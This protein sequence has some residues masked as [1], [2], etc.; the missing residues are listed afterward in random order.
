MKIAPS[1]LNAD[2]LNL[3]VV[4]KQLSEADY[5]HVDVMDGVF[6]PNISFGPDITTQISK[7]TKIPLDVHLMIDDP[8]LYIDDFARAKPDFITVHV[9]SKRY[10][11]ALEKIKSHGIKKGI[12]IKPKTQVQDIID[13]LNYVDLVL[14][15]SVEP[16]FGGQKFMHESLAK[17]EELVKIRQEQNL[18]FVIEVDGG[19]N[20]Q[21][22]L[23][24]KNC[25]ADI[26]V[27][28]SYLMK[29]SNM[30]ETIKSLR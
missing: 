19:I 21:T 10:V 2:F 14:V 22:A 7:G 5:I 6:V 24:V 13:H 15:M 18:N 30:N 20:E 25:G 28:G 23:L 12:S 1:I 16:G 17:I 4:L 26:I 8:V 27:V 9:E 3:G 11:L 29:Q